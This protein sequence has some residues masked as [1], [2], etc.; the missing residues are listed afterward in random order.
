MRGALFPRFAN[1]HCR[2]LAELEGVRGRDVAVE[3]KPRS[4]LRKSALNQAFQN[5]QV[6]FHYAPN[7]FMVD[8]EVMMDYHVP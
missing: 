4:S 8:P 7:D 6:A 1:R 5:G 2:W 3:G